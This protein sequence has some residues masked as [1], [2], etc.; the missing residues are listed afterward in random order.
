MEKGPNEYYKFD[1][2]RICE[3]CIGVILGVVVLF[4]GS[5]LYGPDPVNNPSIVGFIFVVAGI[6]FIIFTI[7][8]AIF[9]HYRHQKRI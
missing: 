8:I 3:Y 7:A 1:M 9:L 5:M 6:G 4:V 2:G